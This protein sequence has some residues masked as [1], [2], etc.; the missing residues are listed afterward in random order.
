MT[1]VDHLG[2]CGR[3][4]VHGISSFSS[5]ATPNCGAPLMNIVEIDCPGEEL[6][7]IAPLQELDANAQTSF[8]RIKS[9]QLTIQVRIPA[10]AA[11]NGAAL[12]SLSHSGLFQAA[13]ASRKTFNRKGRN[14]RFEYTAKTGIWGEAHFGSSRMSAPLASAS[15]Q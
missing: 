2:Y 9:S 6:V 13:S 7:N 8:D 15:S 3:S 1:I 12:Q 5:A 11:T 4:V 14:F 10:S